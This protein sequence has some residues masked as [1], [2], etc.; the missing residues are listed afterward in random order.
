[1]WYR[2]TIFLQVHMVMDFE[3]TSQHPSFSNIF[4][5]Q[6]ISFPWFTPTFPAVL[7][8]HSPSAPSSTATE[9]PVPHEFQCLGAKDICPG[10]VAV[11]GHV[12]EIQT[13]LA[14]AVPGCG[15]QLGMARSRRSLSWL[16]W[17]GKDPPHQCH[18]HFTCEIAPFSNLAFGSL[19]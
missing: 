3:F 9:V 6:S 18:D 14:V 16:G 7:P 15:Q 1:M 10:G 2:L 4:S 5:Y 12:D 8:T 13:H 19:T 11:A 17:A